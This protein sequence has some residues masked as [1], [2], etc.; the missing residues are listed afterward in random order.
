MLSFFELE[1]PDLA[2]D[3]L[4]EFGQVVLQVPRGRVKSTSSPLA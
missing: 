4:V 2:L 1:R 3:E